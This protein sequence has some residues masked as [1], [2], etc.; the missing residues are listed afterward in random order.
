MRASENPT[1]RNQHGLLILPD[2]PPRNFSYRRVGF[3]DVADMV[4]R[5]DERRCRPVPGF[6]DTLPLW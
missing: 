5:N 4:S 6:I 3:I 2:G 1:L